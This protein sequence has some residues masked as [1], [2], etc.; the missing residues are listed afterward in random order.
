MCSMPFVPA[1]AMMMICQKKEK[2]YILTV[3]TVRLFIETYA[4]HLKLLTHPTV[5]PFPYTTKIAMIRC[6]I[7][8][9][10]LAHRHVATALIPALTPALIPTLIPALIPA[11]LPE[12][13]VRR[14]EKV[15]RF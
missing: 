13:S 14:C 7:A 9:K 12:G 5:N 11:S 3:G 15:R 1:G 6:Y 4:K 10:V 8:L 2:R